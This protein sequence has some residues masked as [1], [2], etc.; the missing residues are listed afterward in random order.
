VGSVLFR[1]HSASKI[2]IMQPDCS[3]LPVAIQKD[4]HE[5]RGGEKQARLRLP[6][7]LSFKDVHHPC[8][9]GGRAKSGPC[10]LHGLATRFFL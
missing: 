8:W 5:P 10:P 2:F 9:G 1:H 6:H 7:S 4:D 3:P